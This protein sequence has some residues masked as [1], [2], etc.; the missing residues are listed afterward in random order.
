MFETLYVCRHAV[1]VD[2]EE[3]HGDDAE[4]PLTRRGARRFL[5]LAR[6]LNASNAFRPKLVVTSPLLRAMETAELIAAETGA[7][8]VQCSQLAPGGDQNELLGNVLQYEAKR[9]ALVGHSPDLDETAARL[10]HAP[11]SSIKLFKGSV[12]AL[13]IRGL[14]RNPEGHEP[15]Q[16]ASTITAQLAYYATT[17]MLDV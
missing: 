2:R 4:R 5:A 14:E 3:F 13:R 8:I 10:L 16:S 7:E 1:A 11:K 6:I 17:A 15:A 9:I 12:L